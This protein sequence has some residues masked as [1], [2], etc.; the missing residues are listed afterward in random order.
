[1]AMGVD[2]RSR[3]GA[4]RQ[5]LDTRI[6]IR[7]RSGKNTGQQHWNQNDWN[8]ENIIRNCVPC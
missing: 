5:K 6:H 3:G 2:R 4:V 7:K 1:M 8:L